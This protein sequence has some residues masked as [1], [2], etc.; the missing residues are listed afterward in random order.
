MIKKFKIFER[1]YSDNVEELVDV[2]SSSFIEKYYDKHF[3]YTDIRDILDMVSTSEILYAFDDN[4]YK[5]EYIRGYIDSQTLSD[6]DKSD[7]KSYIE[8]NMTS[9]KEEKILDIYNSNNVDE[10]NDL[11]SEIDGVVSIKETKKGNTIITV[12]SETGEFKRYKKP[13][14]GTV[15]VEDGDT[16]SEGELLS[17]ERESSYESYMLDELDASELR[18]VIEDSG[19]ESK[20]IEDIIE[21]WYYRQSGEDILED[22]YGDLNKLEPQ[23]LYDPY[24][25][26]AKKSYSYYGSNKLSGII[27]DYVDEKKLLKRYNQYEDFDHKKETIKDNIEHKAKIQREIFNSDPSKVLLLAEV[28]ESSS[29][30]IGDEYDFQLA[31]IN[32]YTEENADENDADDVAETKADALLYLDDNFGLDDDIRREFD[33]FMYKVN[34]KKYNI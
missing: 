1:Y 33:K 20:C 21:G 25:S 5:E 8:E 22:L 9:E 28:I 2:L 27:N 3:A 14:F 24:P 29:N 4:R 16:V 23:E 34:A 19:E 12:R 31:Y 13:K 18:D 7:L 26:P 30:N 6:F 11:K 32:K 17:T 10:D 15:I